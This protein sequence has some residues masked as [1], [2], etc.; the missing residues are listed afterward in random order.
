VSFSLVQGVAL[1]AT[2]NIIGNVAHAFRPADAVFLCSAVLVA[3]AITGTPAQLSA[4][5][6]CRR[7]H[8]RPT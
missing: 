3:C 6:Q 5:S 7:A 1:L 2:N 8:K 4:A